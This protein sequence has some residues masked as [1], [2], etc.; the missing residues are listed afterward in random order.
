[1]E[2]R[3]IR[4][5]KTYESRLK[6]AV[7]VVL[8]RPAVVSEIIGKI[9]ETFHLSKPQKITSHIH[10]M[11]KSGILR[12]LTPKLKKTQQG[13]VYGL[14]AKGVR[15]KKQLAKKAGKKFSYNELSGVNWHNYG[16]CLIGRQKKAV[17]LALDRKPLRQVEILRKLRENYT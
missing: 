13:K 11:E 16:W 17:L 15:Y 9:T 3:N 4:H 6:Q 12:V 14:T 5:P 10:D 1:M 7:I 8:D 2:K